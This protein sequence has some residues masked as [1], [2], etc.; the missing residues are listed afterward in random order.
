MKVLLSGI[1][2][3][4]GYQVID[5]FYTVLSG[6]NY[7]I[8]AHRDDMLTFVDVDE[9]FKKTTIKYD[10]RTRSIVLYHT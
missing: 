3:E 2:R 10:I 1:S 5:A 7:P 6:M 9:G 8:T 4:I